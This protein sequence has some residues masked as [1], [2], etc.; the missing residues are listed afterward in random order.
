MLHRLVGAT[1]AVALL[2][3]RGR[4]SAP[5]SYSIVARWEAPQDA[6]TIKLVGILM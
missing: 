3:P 4:P 1:L 5:L 2:S 6:R